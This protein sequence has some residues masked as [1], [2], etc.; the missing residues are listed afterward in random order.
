MSLV[1]QNIDPPPPSPPGE[2]VLPPNKGG[3]VQNRRAERGMGGSIFWKTI[4]IGLPSYGNNLSTCRTKRAPHR[5][6]SLQS[7]SL[8]CAFSYFLVYVRFIFF[9][10]QYNHFLLTK[11]QYYME[12]LSLFFWCCL[13]KRS[14]RCTADI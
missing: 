9:I 7:V 2:C 3:G 12:E 10:L 5:S 1:F 8:L 14:L 11:L 4:D 13:A 6:S